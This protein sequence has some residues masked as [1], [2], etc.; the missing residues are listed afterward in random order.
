MYT[1][2]PGYS[3]SKSTKKLASVPALLEGLAPVP[4]GHAVDCMSTFPEAGKATP[5]EGTFRRSSSSAIYEL[6]NLGLPGPHF[7]LPPGESGVRIR[8][9]LCKALST[10]WHT[11]GIPQTAGVFNITDPI[12]LT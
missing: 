1:L 2:E 9:N 12:I 5:L 4:T 10:S 3:I 6:C 8:E 11:E 7:P